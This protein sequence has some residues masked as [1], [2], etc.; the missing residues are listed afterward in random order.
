LSV[1]AEIDR[2]P[3]E[4]AG[5]PQIGV[6]VTDLVGFTTRESGNPEGV[7]QAEA[8]VDLRIDPQLRSLPQPPTDVERGVRGLASRI[9]IEAVGPAIWGMEWGC[10]LAQKSR[11]AVYGPVIGI[12]ERGS[13]HLAVGPASSLA[14]SPT[15]T[16]CI[17]K[18]DMKVWPPGAN[19]TELRPNCS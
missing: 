1:A 15:R 11:L 8:L 12:K 3:D 9:R 4:H 5:Q 7:A 10:I 17:D 13:R 2:L 14:L 6:A 19:V 18:S 16:S